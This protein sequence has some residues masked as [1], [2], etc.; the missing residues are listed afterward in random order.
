MVLKVHICIPVGPQCHQLAVCIQQIGLR[1]ALFRHLIH[2]GQQVLDPGSTIRARLYFVH[3]VAIHGPHFEDGARHRL[4]GVRI[5]LV[6]RQVGP[7][8]VLDG[9]SACSSRKE[10]YFVFLGVDDVVRR[11]GR[12]LH[13]ID[14]RLQITHQDLPCLVGGAVQVMGAILDLGDAERNACQRR[15]VCA[16]LYQTQGGLDAVGEYKLTCLPGLQVNDPLGVI[17]DIPIG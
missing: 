16:Q 3:P 12:L 7:L 17:D 10:L 6:N 14:A 15:A 11:G 2:A 1:H 9:Q 5:P 13:R 8:I 4:A